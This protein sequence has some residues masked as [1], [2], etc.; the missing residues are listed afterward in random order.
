[1]T[2]SAVGGES[3]LGPEF[4][5]FQV[6]IEDF[7][8]THTEIEKYINFVELPFLKQVKRS[9]KGKQVDAATGLMVYHSPQPPYMTWDD[10]KFD[11]RI[12]LR[13]GAD[14][15]NPGDMGPPYAS[16][17]ALVSPV[18]RA[19]QNCQQKTLSIV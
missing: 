5:L 10:K 18:N 14:P 11:N 15:A 6:A 1:M 12:Y 16:Q 3:C 7:Y 4:A 17:T 8:G 9:L 19:T 13:P 2:I